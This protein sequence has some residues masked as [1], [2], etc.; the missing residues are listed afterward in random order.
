[1]NSEEDRKIV[2]R[3]LDG[4]KAA[5]RMLIDRHRAPAV[6]F[7]RRLLGREDAEDAVQEALLAAFLSLGK[8]RE[9][10]RFG[11]WLL[12]IVLNVSR[13]RLRMLREGYFLD[14]VGGQVVTGFRLEDLAP[15][16]EATVEAREL[17]RIV[18]ERHCP[19]PSGKR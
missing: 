18:S 10:D 11:S 13:A 3:V 6:A 8:L 12:G 5:F 7:A 16:T 1:M 2:R 14:P 15:S 17:H 4:D 19:H 9:P